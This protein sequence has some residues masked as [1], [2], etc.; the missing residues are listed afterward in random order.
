MLRQI[1]WVV[2]NRPITKNGVLPLLPLFFVVVVVVVVVVFCFP[3]VF[4]FFGKF[5]FSIANN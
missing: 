5:N 4:L 3:F 2:Q 1:E